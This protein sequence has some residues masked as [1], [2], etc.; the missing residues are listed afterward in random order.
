MGR[1]KTITRR[2]FVIGS[3]AIAGGVVFGYWKYQQPYGNPLLDDLANGETA[4]TPYIRIDH[5]G[6]TIITPRAEMGQGVHTG[7]N[8]AGDGAFPPG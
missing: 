4:L 1:L 7:P 6:V 3:A 2:T 5:A 8:A